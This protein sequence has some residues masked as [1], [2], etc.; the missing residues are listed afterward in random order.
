MGKKK[1]ENKLWLIVWYDG[2]S[3][4]EPKYIPHRISCAYLDTSHSDWKYV[5]FPNRAGIMGKW[6]RCEWMGECLP[7]DY[8]FE[9]VDR[10]WKGLEGMKVEELIDITPYLIAD[11]I[12][13]LERGITREQEEL[14]KIKLFQAELKL[15]KYPDCVNHH[16]SADTY[17]TN[18]CGWDHEDY[19]RLHK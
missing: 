5:S 7:L 16:L 14:A 18:G 8:L 3:D 2:D 9:G 15:C 12:D 17:C 10:H 1:E 11:D 4:D 13:S 19:L 6:K